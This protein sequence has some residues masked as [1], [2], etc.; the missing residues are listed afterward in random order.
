MVID[1]SALVAMLLGENEAKRIT[2]A[3]VGADIRLVSAFS[4]LETAIVIVSKK[5]ISGQQDLDALSER[6]NLEVTPLTPEQVKLGRDA[7]YQFGKGRHPAALNIGDCCSYALAKASGYQLL[8]KG[9]DFPL[10]DLELIAY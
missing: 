10:T 2:R 8:C 7:W 3:I 6:H 9:A 4:M 1:S 5:G